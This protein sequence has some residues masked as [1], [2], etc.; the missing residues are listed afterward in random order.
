LAELKQKVLSGLKWSVGGRAASQ[1]ATWAS[2]IIVMRLLQPD[3]Y[4]LMAMATFFIS[5]CM[6]LNELGMSAALVQ[7]KELTDSLLRQM[8]GIVI[9]GNGTLFILLTVTSP[10]IARFF[11]E[12]RLTAIVSVLAI[13]F[14]LIAFSVIPNARLARE[15][16]FRG[17]SIVEVI[18]MVSSAIVTLTMAWL[19]YGVWSLVT[20][21]LLNILLRS[22]GYNIICPSL[23]KPSF[24]FRGFSDRA[25][26]GGYVSVNRILWYLYSH[27]D[28]FIVGKLL[29]KTLL[30]YYSVAMHVASLPMQKVG[31]IL[32]Q[33]A[34]PAYSQLQDNRELAA[35]YALKASR[36]L[37]FFAFPIFFGIS[38]V[39]PEIISVVL[40]EKWLPAIV[41][42]QLLSLIIPLRTIQISIGPA[43]NGLGRPDVNTRNM[44]V[45]CIIMPVSFLIGSYWGLLG[46]SL[47][48]IIAYS[49][50]FVYMLS[51]SLKVI[52]ASMSE[53]FK[54]MQ[55]PA[56]Y[57]AAMYFAVYMV[58]ILLTGLDANAILTLIL[59]IATG[60]IVYGGGMLL[61][62]R[63]S[64]KEIWSMMRS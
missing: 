14:P 18:A 13:Q 27:A 25:K 23:I 11:N 12:P 20:G 21:S 30:G 59:M 43:V 36:A 64:C 62:E 33:V 46:V 60:A 26:F 40:G 5:L 55:V 50:W 53:F 22:T 6:L 61:F 8:F 38:S 41:P 35:A 48:W 7:A 3:D 56:L 9:I 42:L 37:S 34:L 1:L 49:L 10:L 39:A 54:T 31:S 32:Q 29:G 58:K 28:V 47:A 45:A 52:G 2:T 4:G 57:S 19:G 15:M 16:N 24:N 51:R 17:K 44:I 63:T